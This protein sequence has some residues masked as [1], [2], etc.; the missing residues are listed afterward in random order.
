MTV[1]VLNAPAGPASSPGAVAADEATVVLTSPVWNFGIVP[2][3]SADMAPAIV[4][5]LTYLANLPGSRHIAAALGPGIFQLKSKPDGKNCITLP[6]DLA[7]VDFGGA[8]DGDD[9]NSPTVLQVPTDLGPGGTKGPGWEPV[10]WAIAPKGTQTASGAT[11]GGSYKYHVHDLTVFGPNQS[12][13]LGQS[14]CTMGGILAYERGVIE[15]VTVNGNFFT[16]CGVLETHQS[17]RDCNFGGGAYS[18][19]WLT[20]GGFGDHKMDRVFLTGSTFASVGVSHGGTIAQAIWEQCHFG[21]GPYWFMRYTADLAPTTPRSTFLK[22]NEFIRCSMEGM[23]NGGIFDRAGIIDGTLAAGVDDLKFRGPGESSNWS[24]GGTGGQFWPSDAGMRAII[25]VA[26][27]VSDILYDGGAPSFSAAHNF[28]KANSV[29][30]IETDAV[31]ELEDVATNGKV[32][33]VL[34]GTPNQ[35][36]GPVSIGRGLGEGALRGTACYVDSGSAA[37]SQFDL[38]EKTG[39]DTIRKHTNS[40]TSKVVGVAIRL[41]GEVPGDVA[42]IWNGGRS[43][44]LMVRNLSGSTITNGALITPDTAHPGS[45][46]AATSWNDGQIIGRLVG[47]LTTGN[48][49]PAELF[50]LSG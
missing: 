34:T 12:K 9:L 28:V 19:Q 29:G 22:G 16:Q 32:H 49:G 6:T 26:A 39:F 44:S 8:G 31:N 17:F 38:V 35:R 18:M 7:S 13:V 5:A 25:E 41:G 30:K 2:N 1:T 37:I 3:T 48:V 23:G 27:G 10:N 33:F 42:V 46:R 43:S 45:V 50:N 20:S 21:F 4:A 11:G 40:A 47:T 14:A 15:R 24:G 36:V